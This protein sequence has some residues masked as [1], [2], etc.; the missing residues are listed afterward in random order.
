MIRKYALVM[1]LAVLILS[2]LTGVASAQ[3]NDPS[4]EKL[5]SILGKYHSPLPAQ[6]IMDFYRSHSDFDVGRFLT[7][8]WCESSLG[9]AGKSR[10]HHN[11]GNIIF[12]GWSSRNPKYFE[13]RPWLLWQNGYFHSRGQRFGTY[14]SLEIGTKAAMTLLSEKYTAIWHDWSRFGSIYYGK[15][16]G[17]T[18]YV[19]EL[20]SAHRLLVREAAAVGWR[21]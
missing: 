5:Q 19:S 16:A 2:A 3:G 1:L 12:A 6:D 14:S 18:E 4:T 17:V 13:A 15:K 9:T 21:W 7:V 20:K 8:M 10:D 11:P